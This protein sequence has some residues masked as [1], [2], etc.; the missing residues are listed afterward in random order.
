MD[1]VPRSAPAGEQAESW[2]TG[3]LA[4]KTDSLFM[5]CVVSALGRWSRNC[6]LRL[7]L[8]WVKTDL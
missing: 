4:Q 5:K 7:S 6:C 2:G 3:H 8:F 1:T